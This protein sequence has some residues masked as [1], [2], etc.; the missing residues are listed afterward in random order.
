MSVVGWDRRR[1]RRYAFR[2]TGFLKSAVYTRALG[3]NVL[4]G[5]NREWGMMVRL[6]Q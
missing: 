4:I 2:G 5:G 6:P 3:V 1:R